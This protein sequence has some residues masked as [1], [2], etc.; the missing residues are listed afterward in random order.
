MVE[1]LG[2]AQYVGIDVSTRYIERARSAFGDRAEF[3]VADATRIDD[4]L[5]AF[6][7]VL[8]VGVI[9]H[10]DDEGAVRLL[11][12][13]LG[14]L[15]PGG[16]FVSIDPTVIPDDRAAARLLISWDRGQHVRA[17]AEYQRLAES[18]FGQVKCDVRRDLLRIPYTHCVLECG[19]GTGQ[20]TP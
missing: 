2:D 8:A 15:G 1:Y 14:A 4:D 7:L 19:S 12:G 18:S 10:L 17:P 5:R 16:R 6:D 3:R 9:H 13:A 11:R 20:T